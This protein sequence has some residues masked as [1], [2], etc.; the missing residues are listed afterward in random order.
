MRH[1]N[2]G[3]RLGRRK[4]E[5][6][7][8]A[9]NLTASLF[10]R[11]GADREFIT[12]TIVKAKWVKPFAEKAITLGVKGYRE[13]QRAADANGTTVAELRKMHTEGEKKKFKD[14]PPKVREHIAKSIH[15]RRMAAAQLR[16]ADAVSALFEKIA[17]RYLARP[18]GYLRVLRTG[19]FQLGDNA[20]KALLGFVEGEAAPAEQ[21]PAQ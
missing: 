3:K 10:Q 14:F 20:P 19:Q 1:R 17:P 7:A 16:D 21:Q 12:T 5:R 4:E 2:A 18:G 13:L 9:R 6:L 15:F 8:L 11:F